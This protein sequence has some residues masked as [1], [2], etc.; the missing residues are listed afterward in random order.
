MDSP[1]DSPLTMNEHQM[2][3]IFNQIR[4]EKREEFIRFVSDVLCPAAASLRPVSIC[5][6]RMLEP[7]V[8]NEDGSYTYVVL[9]D[10][11]FQEI[12]EPVRTILTRA[13]GEDGS[14]ELLDTYLACQ[15]N[16]SARYVLTDKDEDES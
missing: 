10:P 2:L 4:P 1:K 11:A 5:Q 14:K 9:L 7:H 12:D 8:V 13:H 6:T 3:V 15:A 16:S